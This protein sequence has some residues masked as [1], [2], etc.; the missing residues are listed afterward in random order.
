MWRGSIRVQTLR[1]LGGP[2]GSRRRPRRAAH[3]NCLITLASQVLSEEKTL[4]RWLCALVFVRSRFA[5]APAIMQRSLLCFRGSWRR[6]CG[7]RSLARAV[8]ARALVFLFFLCE[9]ACAREHGF[10]GRTLARRARDCQTCF[11]LARC[12][13]VC[14]ACWD[15]LADVGF[16]YVARFLFHCFARVWVLLFL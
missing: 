4:V 16:F 8:R 11:V 5:C 6:V 1:G 9:H 7:A 2:G 12:V 15:I 3:T 13:C 10:G 14:G